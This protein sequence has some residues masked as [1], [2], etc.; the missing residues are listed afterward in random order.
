MNNWALFTFHISLAHLCR[1]DL[2]Y[3]DRSISNRK[4]VWLIFVITMFYRNSYSYFA[5]F[6]TRLVAEYCVS[7]LVL[8]HLLM[9]LLRD[10]RHKWVKWV[11]T[12]VANILLNL[13]SLPLIFLQWYVFLDQ[14]IIPY[15]FSASVKSKRTSNLKYIYKS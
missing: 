12:C 6:R 8:H 13:Q 2:N 5:Q 15:M 11:K 4:C 9:S 7:D 14:A 10:A 3:L 1:V